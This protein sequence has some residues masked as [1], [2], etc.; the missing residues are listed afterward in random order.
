MQKNK[1]LIADAVSLTVILFTHWGEGN[2]NRGPTLTNKTEGFDFSITLILSY[3]WF[4]AGVKFA[5]F[6]KSA[7]SEI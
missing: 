4:L 3:V 1:L 7:Q 6:A 2:I 5:K